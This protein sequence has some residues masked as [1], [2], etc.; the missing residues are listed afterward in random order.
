MKIND[1]KRGLTTDEYAKVLNDCIGK[2]EGLNDLDWDEIVTKYNLGIHRD[3]LRKAFQSPMGGYSVYKYLQEELNNNV[4]D[5]ET[6]KLINDKIE[7]LKKERYKLQA[8]KIEYNRNIR[9]DSRFELFYENIKDSKD[10]LP[11]PEFEELQINEND[12]GYV[13]SIADV[14]YGATFESENN[15]YN[16]EEVKTRF[17]VLLQK[18]KKLIYKNNINKLTI[19]ELADTI[20]G[21]LRISDVTL[22]DIPVVDAVV[23]VSRLIA[24][25]LNELSKYTTIEYRHVLS[26]NHGQN[27]YL[28]TR[29]NEMPCEDME[30]IIGNYI[31]DLVS[32]NDRIKVVLSKNDYDSFKICGQNILALHGWQVKN[33]ENSIKDYS[34]L[35]R[36]FYDIC[37]LA[38]FHAGKTI[39][40]G[41]LNGDTKVIVCSGFIGS[42]PYSDKLKKGTKGKCELFKI[43]ENLGITE[44]YTIILN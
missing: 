31:K 2:V 42:D 34:M 9:K 27:R 36:K 1:Y 17:E 28:N 23:E 16:R 20:Q 14:H 32:N 37:F 5:D 29:A 19:I 43:E 12:G 30:R 44:T 18:L 6:I 15:I 7:E 11:L 38:H 22:N 40:V 33:I 39:S 21:M 26:G 41:E 3:V 13:L 24:T 10:R 4:E 25:F 8:T 35:H